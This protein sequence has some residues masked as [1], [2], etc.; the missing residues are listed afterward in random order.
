MKKKVN[1]VTLGCSKNMVDSEVLLKQL[2]ESGYK[3]VHDS[4]DEDAS[5]VIINTCG[6]ILDAKEESI[7]TIMNYVQAKQEGRIEKIYVMGCLAARYKDDLKNEIPEVDRFFG[8]FDLKNIVDE[9][10]AEYNPDLIYDRKITTPSH[11]AYLKISEGCN[12]SCAFCAIPLITGR[13]QSKPIEALIKETKNLAA[14]GVKELLIIA[15][16]ISYYGIDLYGKNMLGEL[17]EKISEVDGIEWIRLH[18]AYPTKFPFEILPLMRQNPKVCKYLDIPVQHCSDNVLKSMLRHVTKAETV[19]LINKIR[20]EV[21]DIALR[22]T[23][24]VGYPGETEEYFEELKEFIQEMRFERLGVFPYSH[25]EDT[26]A[27]KHYEDVLPQIIKQERADEIMEIQQSISAEIMN[28]KVGQTLNVI[29]DRK[30]GDYY[31]GRTEFDSPDVDGEVFIQTTKRLRKGSFVKAHIV[32]S[33]D[34]DLYAEY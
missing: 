13:Y 31:V 4:N 16:D 15:Q 5:V 22:T 29:V 34:Y 30:E 26:Y 8:K 2:E 3:V 14:K 17:I 27:Y 19:E 11:Y 18:Y 6:F 12:R 33:E 28:A 1:V 32:R 9:L 21:P 24:L 7:D 20:E 23:L 25:E 10:K